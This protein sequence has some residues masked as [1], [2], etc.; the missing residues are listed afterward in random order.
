VRSITGTY[1][2]I[3]RTYTATRQTDPT[4][5]AAIYAALGDARTV[6]NVGAGTGSYE[7]TDRWVLAVE[8]SETMI[9]QRPPGAAPVVRATAEVLPLADDTVDAAMALLTV[10]HSSDWRAGLAELRRVARDRVVLW[11]FQPHV[12]FWLTQDYVPEIVAMERDRC[13]RV[14]ELL[15]ALGPDADARPLP[16]PRECQDGILAAF[17]AR[18]ETYLDP[19][20]RAGMS[21]FAL[22]PPAIVAAA[23]DRLAADLRSGA[24]DERHGHLRSQ[25]ELEAG[26]RLVIS[27][28][29]TPS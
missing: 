19:A 14:D 27:S 21:G 7:P 13:P 1:D 8:P 28:A 29:A 26:Y 17:Y 5:A 16:I 23:M 9:R 15:A 18:P 6:V 2:Q 11:V 3:G 22:L 4:I 12:D 20:V 10:H 24:W 25:P